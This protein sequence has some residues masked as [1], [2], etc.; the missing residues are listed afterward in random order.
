MQAYCID[1]HLQTLFSYAEQVQQ[2]TDADT[3]YL[4][5]QSPCLARKRMCASSLAKS[6]QV[7]PWESS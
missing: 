4:N 2:I 5:F 7:V 1:V 6:V 3:L